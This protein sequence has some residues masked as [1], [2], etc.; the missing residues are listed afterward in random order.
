MYLQYKIRTESSWLF[1]IRHSFCALWP[2][3]LWP[4][5]FIASTASV[6]S[7][8]QTLHPPNTKYPCHTPWCTWSQHSYC[9]PDCCCLLTHLTCVC[10]CIYICAHFQYYNTAL[11]SYKY[12]ANTIAT[13]KKFALLCIYIFSSEQ[14]SNANI[15]VFLWQLFSL[16]I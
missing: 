2:R 10:V 16:E 8:P 4:T 1:I 13:E 7:F 11:N 3:Y 9:H 6:L 12:T 14:T 15:C 5:G